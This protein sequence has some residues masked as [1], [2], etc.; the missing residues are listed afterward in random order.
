MISIKKMDNRC[1]LCV[2]LFKYFHVLNL[3][4]GPIKLNL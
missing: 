2:E 4:I 3:N 1:D